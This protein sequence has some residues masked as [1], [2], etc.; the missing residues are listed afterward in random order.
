MWQPPALYASTARSRSSSSAITWARVA[1]SI[2]GGPDDSYYPVSVP[3]TLESNACRSVAGSWLQQAPWSWRLRARPGWLLWE[4]YQRGPGMLTVTATSARAHGTTSASTTAG[5][6]PLEAPRTAWR[7][8]ASRTGCPSCLGAKANRAADFPLAADSQ[9]V[10]V[11]RLQSDR[12]EQPRA[13]AWAGPTEAATWG[14]RKPPAR[15]ARPGAPTLARA[16]RRFAAGACPAGGRRCDAGG[17][18]R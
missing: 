12:C 3:L 13:G 11:G 17:R 8:S 10:P 14:V 2:A 1:G 16:L 18:S 6:L 5:V 7:S 4:K 9:Y 15:G